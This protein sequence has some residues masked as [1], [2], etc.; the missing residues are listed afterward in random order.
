MSAKKKAKKNKIKLAIHCGVAVPEKAVMDLLRLDCAGKLY[1]FGRQFESLPPAEVFEQMKSLEEV[2]AVT[3]GVLA[4]VQNQWKD[5]FKKPEKKAEC[6]ACKPPKK[7]KPAKG[8]KTAKPAKP[9]KAK[10]ILSEIEQRKVRALRKRGL[11]IK[12]IAKEIHRA[13]KVVADFV[14]AL[15]KKK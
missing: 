14:R 13:E 8:K 9:K 1:E 4:I 11:P 5:A 7:A 3:A 6:T 2:L 12:A 15:P 10:A